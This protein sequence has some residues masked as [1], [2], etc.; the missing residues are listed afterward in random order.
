MLI[1]IIFAAYHHL[2]SVLTYIIHTNFIVKFM[3]KTRI[4]VV[5]SLIQ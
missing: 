4:M 3:M 5:N 1:F 2:E